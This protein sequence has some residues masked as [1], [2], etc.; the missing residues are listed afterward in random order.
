MGFLGGELLDH[1]FKVYLKKLFNIRKCKLKSNEISLNTY[2]TAKIKKKIIALVDVVQLVGHC[3]LHGR[4]AGWIPVQSTCHS[5]R[6]AGGNQ[7]MFLVLFFSFSLFLSISLSVS[8]I[9][10]YCQKA[11]QNRYQFI[12]PSVVWRSQI[13]SY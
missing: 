6:H 2:I 12:F 1:D 4:V 8:R 13:S 3:P 5:R 10:M 11:V 7:W 9:H